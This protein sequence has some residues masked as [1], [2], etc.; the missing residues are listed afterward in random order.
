MKKLLIILFAFLLICSFSRTANAQDPSEL[1][2]QCSKNAGSDTK[3]L[4]DFVV[5]FPE[6]N[7]QDNIPIHKNTAL[8][9]K[10]THYRLSICN[11]DD[12]KGEG[13]IQLY[14]D[15]KKIA[16]SL[17]PSGKIYSSIDFPCQKTGSY[18]IWISFK[19]GEEGYAVGIL[20]FVNK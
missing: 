13:I 12:S 5:K 8:L 17:A 3:Y 14:S 4:K 6:A 7:S 10:N 18:Q 15:G 2:F 20:S 19:D 11:S 9:L 16:S 1:V